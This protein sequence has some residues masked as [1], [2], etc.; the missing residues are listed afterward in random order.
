MTS[1]IVLISN[2][3]WSVVNFRA[4]LINAL[5]EAGYRML[6]AAPEDEYA[7]RLV[8]SGCRYVP[9]PMDNK[10]K[11]PI[12]DVILVSR[13]WLMLQRADSRQKSIF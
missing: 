1:T 8:E 13:L 10:G 12:R 4:G 5:Q 3:A 11:N 6:V 2:T 7:A 9:I